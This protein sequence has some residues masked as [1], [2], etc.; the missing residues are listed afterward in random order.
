MSKED[1]KEIR[2]PVVRSIIAAVRRTGGDLTP[3]SVEIIEDYII[4]L[5]TAMK[6]GK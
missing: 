1:I 4:G 5:E 3:R 2:D 6:E